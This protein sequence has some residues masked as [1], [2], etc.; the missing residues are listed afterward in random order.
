MS[1]RNSPFSSLAS[2]RIRRRVIFR[3]YTGYPAIHKTCC[4]TKAIAPSFG[5][6]RERAITGIRYTSGD[7]RSGTRGAGRIRQNPCRRPGHGRRLNMLYL[8]VKTIGRRDRLRDIRIEIRGEPLAG[9]PVRCVSRQCHEQKK[10]HETRCYAALQNTARDIANRDGSCQIYCPF[11]WPRNPCGTLII[12][13]FLE[14]RSNPAQLSIFA[15]ATSIGRCDVFNG[16][17]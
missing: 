1:F 3:R 2:P 7:S 10:T 11:E 16:I 15:A 9:R 8:H 17:S 12:R 5:F 4:L 14:N 13:L 6:S